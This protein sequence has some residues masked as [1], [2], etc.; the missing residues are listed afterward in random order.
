[1]GLLDGKVAFVTGAARGQGRSHAI[2]LA[3]EGADV[4]V[5]DICEDIGS[6]PYPLGT[7]D[8]L[9]ET[10]AAVEQLDR[11]IVARAVD[12][13][14]QDALRAAVDEGVA[15][16]GRLDIVVANAGIAAFGSG[17]PAVQ[18][19]DII[20]VNLVGT[21]HTLEAAVPHVV[22]GAEGGSIIVISSSAGTNGKTSEIGPGTQ[23]YVASKHAVIGLMRNYALAL[24]QN[25][26][27]VNV[28]TPCG[29]DTP[30][31]NFDR[32]G[33][34]HE[35]AAELPWDL[36]NVIPVPYVQP[37]DISDAVVWLASDAAKYVTGVVLPVD[38]GYA[39]K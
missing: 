19:R 35:K 18:F 27:R 17:V 13:R 24:G 8:E 33:A 23:A 31:I 16:L 9:A 32:G 28:I 21:W 2:R 25:H 36:S 15:I 10:V 20:D 4:I 34:I 3:R 14:D 5:V 39:L 7:A 29:V 6:V 22:A 12:T 37:D 26:I 11:R 1:M 38:A 30:M